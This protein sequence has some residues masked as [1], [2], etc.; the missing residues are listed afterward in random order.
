MGKGGCFW[1]L[2]NRAIVLLWK[3]EINHIAFVGH[4]E[5]SVFKKIVIIKSV[6]K[7]VVFLLVFLPS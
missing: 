7:K 6:C 2:C 5:L 1:L 3:K 4:E